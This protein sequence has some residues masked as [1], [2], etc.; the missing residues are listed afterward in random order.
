MEFPR[1]ADVAMKTLPPNLDTP[2]SSKNSREEKDFKATTAED[3]ASEAVGPEDDIT[4]HYLTFDTAIPQST[5]ILQPSSTDAETRQPPPPC[6]DLRKYQNP[7]EWSRKSK[8]PRHVNTES[9]GLVYPTSRV[10]RKHC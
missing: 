5:A 7:F 2:L 9:T 8:I 1:E 4:W 3:S 10:R 6:P